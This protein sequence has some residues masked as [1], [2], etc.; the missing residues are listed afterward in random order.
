[1]DVLGVKPRILIMEDDPSIGTAT[2][3]LLDQLGDDVHWAASALHV[4]S[5]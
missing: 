1:M 2:K 3:G 5:A 4:Y